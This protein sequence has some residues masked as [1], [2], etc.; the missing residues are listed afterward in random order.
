MASYTISSTQLHDA[1]LM[2]C[3]QQEKSKYT[4]FDF[5]DLDIIFNVALNA[6]DR[7]PNINIPGQPNEFQYISRWV[8]GYYEARN[9]LPSNRSA[10]PKS[11]CTDPAIKI[12][13]Q[14]SQRLSD[15]QAQFGELF[16]NLFMS[17]ENIQG[18]LLEEYIAWKVRRYGFIWCAGNVLRATDFCNSD[19][20]FLLQVKNKSNTENSSSSTIRD[21]TSIEKW[22]RLGS[23]R[24]NCQIIPD[25]KWEKLND[26]I[27]N[28]RSQ[29][30]K[31]P[32]C[33]MSEDDYERFLFNIA[34]QNNDL[35]TNK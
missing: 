5:A 27:S 21:G 20:S 32:R 17:A 33:Q 1:M 11:A 29:G 16:H 35:I 14:A 22:Y 8:H 7:F 23:K 26:L 18:N 19:G 2:Q 10:S 34:S 13:V 30:F 6:R 15:Q 25:F 12:I 31:L 4:A 3:Y 28:H 9:N 24:R